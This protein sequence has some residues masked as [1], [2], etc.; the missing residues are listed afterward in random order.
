[1]KIGADEIL[2][3]SYRN[4]RCQVGRHCTFWFRDRTTHLRLPERVS[5]HVGLEKLVFRIFYNVLN[6]WKKNSGAKSKDE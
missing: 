6:K 1:M 4:L 3:R 5:R 2:E